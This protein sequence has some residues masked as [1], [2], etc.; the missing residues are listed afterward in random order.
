MTL[1]KDGRLIW[2]IGVAVVVSSIL[3]FSVHLWGRLAAYAALVGG[4][5]GATPLASTTVE[6][7]VP[8]V[9]DG[10]SG[11]LAFLGPTNI[12]IGDL[13]FGSN[14]IAVNGAMK[15]TFMSF[16]TSS[17][18]AS[19]TVKS[20]TIRLRTYYLHNADNTTLEVVS[21]WQGGLLAIDDWNRVG[22]TSFG[23]RWLSE[24]HE[25]E[26]G[27]L[28]LTSEGISAM[29][30]AGITQ[31]ALRLGLDIYRQMPTG[32][33]I[34]YTQLQQHDS[35]AMKLLVTYE[36]PTP[37]PVPPTPTPVP[38]TATPVPPTPTF[39]PVPP[40]PTYT[41]SPTPTSTS[42]PTPAATSTPTATPP[43]Q[44]PPPPPAPGTAVK[45]SAGWNIVAGPAG[46]T[47]QQAA[48]ILYTYQTS[49]GYALLPNTQGVTAGWG[50]WASFSSDTTV[51]ISGTGS[52]SYTTTLDPGQMKIVGNPS[53]LKSATVTA[54][55][56]WTYEPTS[57]YTRYQ[58]SATLPVGRGAWVYS[59]QGGAVTVATTGTS[60]P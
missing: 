13:C 11:T 49:G 8:V 37:T 56:I 50:Y 57:G 4:P 26:M 32:N 59:V 18:P 33:N 14:M 29:N 17:I 16:D 34:V 2:R 7:P 38:P 24:M 36:M 39:T 44:G 58:G 35:F 51:T 43:G 40:T 21:A 3:V 47:F 42:T 19:A 30:R 41:P 46:T 53:G 9:C 20:A 31:F 1:G 60:V 25:G 15:R 45:Y 52:A 10:S 5:L 54:D 28:P 6:L 48:A 23:R 22:S 55:V 12:Q 27:T